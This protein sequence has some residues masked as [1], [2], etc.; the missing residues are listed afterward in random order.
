MRLLVTMAVPREEITTREVGR[1]GYIFAGARIEIVDWEAKECLQA[2]EYTP[3]AEHLGEGCSVRFTGGCPHGGKWYQA[4]GTEIVVYQPGT[5]QIERVISHPSFHDLHGITVVDDAFVVVNTGLDMMQFLGP[6]GQVVRECNL[7][8]VP[9]W[10]RFDRSTDYRRVV[11]TKPHEIH[12]NHAV[13]I[14]GE[15]WVTRCLKSDAININNPEDRID[16]GVGNPHDGVIRGDFIYFTT[17]NGHLAIANVATRK[18]EEI[19]DLNKL[20]PHGTKIGWCRGLEVEGDQA[21]VGFTRIR[22]SKWSGV[23]QTAK[24]VYYGRKRNSHVERIDLSSKEL[25]DSY[26]Y[27]TRGSSAIFTLMNY[28][29]VLGKL[30]V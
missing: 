10:E 2:I 5:W 4:S 15:W 29:R 27:E 14:D 1:E 23:F 26:D 9:T 7:A 8:S 18:I 17:T 21:Y 11:S 22:H 3:P 28:D 25:V 16:I 24:D 20:N 6:D 12:P 13:R 19:I 30:P